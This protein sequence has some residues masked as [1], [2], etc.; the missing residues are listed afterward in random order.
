MQKNRINNPK[1]A[2]ERFSCDKD[3]LEPPYYILLVRLVIQKTWNLG[4]LTYKS[5]L[6]F[7]T[8]LNMH[9]AW[10]LYGGWWDI[11]PC[12]YLVCHK[13]QSE[14]CSGSVHVLPKL[15]SPRFAHKTTCS[16]LPS[17]LK[18]TSACR[19]LSASFIKTGHL[20]RMHHQ[21]RLWS[22]TKRIKL[23]CQLASLKGFNIYK[24]DSTKGLSSA[25]DVGG[26]NPHCKAGGSCRPLKCAHTQTHTYPVFY[27]CSIE[28]LRSDRGINLCMDLSLQMVFC[29]FAFRQHTLHS[30]FCLY[31]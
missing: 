26:L 2:V 21:K 6:I 23:W 17:P 22:M 8:D 13:L 10:W 4:T 18:V 9:L 14:V 12:L 24:S 19:S 29:V 16:D 7:L 3:I 28:S 1:K 30:V 15:L 25:V 5:L 31:I 27:L 11:C 20:L